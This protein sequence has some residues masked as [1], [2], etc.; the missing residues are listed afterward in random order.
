M[1]L[2]PSKAFCKKNDTP[3]MIEPFHHDIIQWIHESGNVM[4]F[5]ILQQFL[6]FGFQIFFVFQTL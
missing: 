6:S 1:R 2:N 3:T 5:D 4:S